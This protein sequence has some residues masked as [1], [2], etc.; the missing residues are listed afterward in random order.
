MY[1]HPVQPG[2]P[3]LSYNVWRFPDSWIK[4]LNYRE[5]TVVFQRRFQ[6]LRNEQYCLVCVASW[7]FVCI[8]YQR[9]ILAR[10]RIRNS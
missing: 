10:A 2:Y 6:C 1:L 5:Q 3:L 8:I 7:D 4:L 9:V